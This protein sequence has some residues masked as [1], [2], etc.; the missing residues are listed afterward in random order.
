MRASPSPWSPKAS[1]GT[2]H[3]VTGE[4]LLDRTFGDRRQRKERAAGTTLDS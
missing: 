3:D 2:T 4:Y 1:L